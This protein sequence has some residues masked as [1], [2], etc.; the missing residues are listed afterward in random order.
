[1]TEATGLPEEPACLKHEG[2]HACSVIRDYIDALRAA[3]EAERRAGQELTDRVRE[4][5][6]NFPFD[7]P[8]AGTAL[9]AGERT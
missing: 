2:G 7:C 5:E 9:R 1:M 6:D 8:L 4:L 3:Y